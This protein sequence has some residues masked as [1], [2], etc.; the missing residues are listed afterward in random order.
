MSRRLLAALGVALPVLAAVPAV[1][2]P[3]PAPPSTPAP[4]AAAAP[5]EALAIPTPAPEVTPVPDADDLASL[6]WAGFGVRFGVYTL[7]VAAEN[8]P[9]FGDEVQ[10]AI[11]IYNRLNPGDQRGSDAL[12][13]HA[14]MVQVIPTVHLGGDGFF[15]RVDVPF[16]FGDELTSLGVNFY[17]LAY[18]YFIERLGLFPYLVAGGGAH[19]L[20]AGTVTARGA[21]VDVS[22]SGAILQGRVALGAKLRTLGRLNGVVEVGYSPWMAAGIVDTVKLDALRDAN[23]ALTVPEPAEAVR[24]GVGSAFDFSVGVEWQ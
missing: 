4:A 19:Y 20:S 6:N 10:E 16:G 22:Q 23:T 5:A 1:A 3:P 12:D 9:I 2:E 18:G 13:L 24:A 15:A 7:D 17:P 14:R 11:D 8:V 21:K